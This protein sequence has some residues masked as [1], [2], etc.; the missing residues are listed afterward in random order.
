MPQASSRS[1][2]DRPLVRYGGAV[3][4]VTGAALIQ[5]IISPLNTLTVV[6]IGAVAI[7]ARWL[8]FGPALLCTAL[9]VLAL[10]YY[11]LQPTH[12]LVATQ[13]EAV[14]LTAFAA[15]AILIASVARQRSLAE[16]IARRFGREK[17]ET[18]EALADRDERLRIGLTVAGMGTWRWEVDA[19]HDWRDA[20]YNAMLGLPAR[21][22][23]QPATDF[24]E[25]LY[26]EDRARVE[27]AVDRTIHEGADYD[28]EFRLRRE[29]GTF[30]WVRDK[31]KLFRDLDGKPLYITGAVID[32]TDR[33][34]QQEELQLSRERFK[35]LFDVN[36]IGICFWTVDGQI[37]EANDE[38]LRIV[39]FTRQEFEM[40]GSIDW[41]TLT[42]SEYKEADDRAIRECMERG[43][44]SVYEKEYEQRDGTRVPIVVGVA[45]L[46]GSKFDGIAF[47]MDNTDRKRAEVTLLKQEKLASAGRLAATIA[48][49]INNPLEA[50]TNLL[51]LTRQAPGLPEN[52]QQMLKTADEELQR[53]TH[54][55]KQ[56]LGFY[57][58]ST[59]ARDVDL[60]QAIGDVLSVYARKLEHR[61]I[62][63]E[64]DFRA[65][66][67]VRAFDGELRQVF[68]NVI[69]NAA[70]AMAQ[71]G[72]LRI[73]LSHAA[74]GPQPFVRVTFADEGSG[75]E[76]AVRSHI[77]EPFF[78]TKRD[79]GTG[80][81]L[82]VTKQLV[83]KHGG[84]IS[85]R[86]STGP[87]H[88]GT[89]F[90][91]VLPERVSQEKRVSA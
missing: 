78:T 31:G 36:M 11:F 26:P 35:R 6:F 22:S 63:V 54:T 34:L 73:R 59:Q 83:E 58:E 86:S 5:H 20:S 33:K 74:D 4:L 23:I 28:I 71:G 17:E 46:T 53:V 44:S 79:V 25:R 9:S 24:L 19:R 77:F 3:L 21:E 48:H 52:A 72:R 76:R 2:L 57:R 87:A 37:T 85:L 38:Y 30:L 18:L 10:D 43:V 29:D 66:P 8:G 16:S 67:I 70:D 90:S 15:V 39:G 65:R 14:R 51:Y 7:A 62:R 91:I 81:G 69:N 89:T 88:R 50:V 55:A 13:T 84:R 47:V 64:T 61:G 60:A 75:I 32:I 45:F 49:E 41:R 80:L 68:S 56:T 40:R 82:W 27:D 1:I 12:R 42:P